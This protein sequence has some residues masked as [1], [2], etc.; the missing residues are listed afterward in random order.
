MGTSAIITGDRKSLDDCLID[1]DADI[2][3]LCGMTGSAAER[4]YAFMKEE[5]WD[6]WQHVF[7]VRDPEQLTPAE[8]QQ[9]FGESASDRYAVLRG[10]TPPKTVVKRGSTSELLDR[11]EPDIIKIDRAF[12]SGIS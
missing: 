1:G 5:T 6:S 3:L 2:F 11:G 12:V 4:I 7:L 10:R 9:W 8:K